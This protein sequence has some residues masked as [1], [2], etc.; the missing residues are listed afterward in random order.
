MAEIKET[1]N[2]N[3]HY[4]DILKR[5]AIAPL[6]EDAMQNTVKSLTHIDAEKSGS[7]NA[8]FMCTIHPGYDYDKVSNK[9]HRLE[10]EALEKKKIADFA[11]FDNDIT[12]YGI[13]GLYFLDQDGVKINL[14]DKLRADK[15][16]INHLEIAALLNQYGLSKEQA[17]F[18]IRA[19]NQNT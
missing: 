9:Y 7:R 12:R 15:K 10:G 4:D 18:V 13:G 5:E 6:I 3:R 16:E 19:S 2:I 11:L 8:Q 14:I 1:Q 17:D